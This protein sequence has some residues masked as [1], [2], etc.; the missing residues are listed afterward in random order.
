MNIIIITISID[1]ARIYVKR[2]NTKTKNEHK[3][4]SFSEF[5]RKIKLHS[6]VCVCILNFFPISHCFHGCC[7]YLTHGNEETTDLIIRL[8]NTS[9]FLLRIRLLQFKTID[10]ISQTKKKISFI[11]IVKMYL[12]GLHSRVVVSNFRAP[13]LLPLLFA[14]CNEYAKWFCHGEL[15]VLDLALKISTSCSI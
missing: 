15:C 5:T 4:I 3:I 13:I 11:Y 2:R 14:V 8:V 7:I 9:Q 6:C 12:I 1:K 10:M